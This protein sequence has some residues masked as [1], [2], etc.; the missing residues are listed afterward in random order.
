M[1]SFSRFTRVVVLSA[2]LLLVVGFVQVSPQSS[3]AYA[4]TQANWPTFGYDAQH[5]AYNPFESIISTSNVS[6][7]ALDW[8]YST[9]ASISSPPVVDNGVLYIGSNNSTLYALDALTGA[10]KWKYTTGGSI[11]KSSAAV[12]N[13]IVYFGST[14]DNLYALDATSG[15]FMWKYSTGAP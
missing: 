7:L 2:L 11:S 14:D 1:R 12:A 3:I 13:G 8:S 4:A 10:V 9:G 5:T 15:A 6:H